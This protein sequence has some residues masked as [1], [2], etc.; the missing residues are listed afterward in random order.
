MRKNTRKATVIEAF[1][2]VA[3]YENGCLNARQTRR[4]FQDMV[5]TDLAFRF[6]EPYPTIAR[7]LIRDGIIKAAR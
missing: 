1:K 4:F 5:D 7:S 6:D 3:D 2:Q